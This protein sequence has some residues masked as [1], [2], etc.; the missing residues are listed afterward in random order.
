MTLQLLSF[1]LL[2]SRERLFLPPGQVYYEWVRKTHFNPLW[3]QHSI[4]FRSCVGPHTLPA[5]PLLTLSARGCV[6][7]G[8]PV[9]MRTWGHLDTGDESVTECTPGRVVTTLPA[10]VSKRTDCNGLSC[11]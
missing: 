8:G 11:V 3:Y 7:L 4:Y 10:K 2:P 9:T 6:F 1:A 5:W